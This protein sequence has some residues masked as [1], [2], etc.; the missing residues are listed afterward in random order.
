MLSL[1][2]LLALP[3]GFTKVEARYVAGQAAVAGQTAPGVKA[4]FVLDTGSPKSVYNGVLPEGWPGPIL[5]IGEY[6]FAVPT[7]KDADFKP[8]L[9]EKGPFPVAGVFGCDFLGDK[10]IVFDPFHGVLALR[11][12]KPLARD[13]AERILRG[14]DPLQKG[15]RL[16]V[17]PLL[18]TEDGL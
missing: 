9:G 15:R 12:G 14:A 7:E 1:V 2:A 8:D 16:A 17:L 6:N 10:Q 3:A 4:W 13:E 18:E 5:K 11:M